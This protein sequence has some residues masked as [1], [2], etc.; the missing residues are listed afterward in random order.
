MGSIPNNS[1]FIFTKLA[2]YTSRFNNETSLHL[3]FHRKS[4]LFKRGIFHSFMDRMCVSC[5]TLQENIYHLLIS[6]PFAS[7]VWESIGEWL[8]FELISESIILNHDQFYSHMRGKVVKSKKISIWLATCWYLWL[9]RNIVI[10]NKFG[11]NIKDTSYHIKLISWNWC[12]LGLKSRSVLYFYNQWRN[13][14]EYLK[15]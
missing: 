5:F 6:C 4:E 9:R 10:F 14:P 8:E 3:K 12:I 15:L 7:R 13:P 2:P 1:F 11:R